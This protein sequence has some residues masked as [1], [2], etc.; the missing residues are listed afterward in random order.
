MNVSAWSIRNPVP[1]ILLFGLLTLLGINGFRALGIQNFPDIELPAVTVTAPSTGVPSSSSRVTARP[2]RSR[3]SRWGSRHRST[4]EASH[5]MA[6]ASARVP[7][8]GAV[9]RITS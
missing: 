4:E 8:P 6:A 7:S 9:T 3:V 2:N 5:V 1:A